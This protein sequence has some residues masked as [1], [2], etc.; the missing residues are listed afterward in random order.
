MTESHLG[1]LPG[2]EPV[3]DPT[4][5]EAEAAAAKVP[6]TMVGGLVKAMRPWQ[7]VKNVLVLAAPAA[8]GSLFEASAALRSSAASSVVRA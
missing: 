4:R 5:A 6:K 1:R 3:D 8:A 7:W 2:I